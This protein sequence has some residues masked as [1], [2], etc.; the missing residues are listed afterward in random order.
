MIGISALLELNVKVSPVV[1]GAVGVTAGPEDVVI[2]PFDGTADV[3]TGTGVTE[4]P[5]VLREYESVYI[6]VPLMLAVAVALDEA[7]EDAALDKI[8]ENSEDSDEDT[9]GYVA[10]MLES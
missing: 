5:D 1:R 7:I 8:P 2:V 10:T 3:S 6:S 9:A 4:A